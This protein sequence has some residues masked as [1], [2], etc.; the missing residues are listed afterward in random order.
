M[1]NTVKNTVRNVTSQKMHWLIWPGVLTLALDQLMKVV[2]AKS[3]R[4]HQAFPIL[5]Q[6]WLL[7]TRVPNSGL[8]F[9]N[10][11][12]VYTPENALWTRYL[13]ALALAFTAILLIR[14]ALKSD[15]GRVSKLVAGGFSIFWFGGFSNV[16]SHYLSIFVDD[17]ISAQ[18]W[19]GS[20][21]FIF[22][23]ADVGISL[24]LF[25]VLI[26]VL[27]ETLR[28]LPPLGAGSDVNIGNS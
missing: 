27:L 11:E 2:T 28:L 15:G 16:L 21:Y 12:M 10:F 23:M 5:E 26:A 17:T 8:L 14:F 20:K 4:P 25:A 7:W 18:L 6:K 9:Q 13:P 24:G 3:I 19:P 22:N 1:E